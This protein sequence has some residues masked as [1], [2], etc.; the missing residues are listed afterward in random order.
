MLA[1]G[2]DVLVLVVTNP[3]S[4]QVRRCLAGWAVATFGSEASGNNTQHAASGTS[5]RHQVTV[6]VLGIR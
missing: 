4:G 3:A 5:M 2:R 6:P 1:G